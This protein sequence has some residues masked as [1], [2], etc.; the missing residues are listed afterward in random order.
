MCIDYYAIID[1]EIISFKRKKFKINGII[2]TKKDIQPLLYAYRN[3]EI[4][5][6]QT[7]LH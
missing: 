4:E 7:K 5:F 2:K 1:T 3:Y 6:Y